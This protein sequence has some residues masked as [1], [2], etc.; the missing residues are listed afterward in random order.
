DGLDEVLD[1][2]TRSYVSNQARAMISEW[3]NRGVR[4]VVTSRF[5]GYRD[6]PLPGSLSHLS[7]LDFRQQEI[8]IFVHKWA[9]AYERWIA[10]GVATPESTRK[11]RDLEADLLTDVRSN[12]SVQR[13]A[14]NP[15][16]LTMLALVRRQVGRLPHRRILLYERYVNTLIE[17]WVEARSQGEH[18]R[19][20]DGLDLHGAEAILIPL[21]LWLQHEK[22]SGTASRSEIQRELTHIYLEEAGVKQPTRP[23][24]REAEEKSIRFLN[25]MR[26]MTGLIV[27][28]GHDAYG[29]LH[30]TFQEYFVGRALA[31][32]DDHKRWQTIQVVRHQPR[33]REPLLLCMGWLGIR[34]NRRLQVTSLVEQIL[35]T[36]D[37]TEVDLHRNLLLALAIAADDVNLHPS[38]FVRLRNEF[39]CCFPTYIYQTA[40]GLIGY[41]GLL[42]TNNAID[43]QEWL[44]PITN[45]SNKRLR[46]VM[47][48]S[49]AEHTEF[50]PVR[51][52]ILNCLQD[53]NNSVRHAAIEAITPLLT[54]Y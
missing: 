3:S 48:E 50:G 43:L 10:G 20:L 31:Q 44:E 22:P 45:C 16:M 40:R 17:S 14:A 5:V 26:H 23:Q 37:K 34:E 19:S 9:H 6:A 25:E 32:L 15:L 51:Q 13:L 28:R 35:D 38:I 36:P 52:H 39:V 47:V 41:A 21:S 8:E 27:E 33:W 12:P 42:A 4:F 11:A 29:F 18:T 54:D 53:K 7:V 49:L 46:Q 1:T 24:Q 2:G 30:L